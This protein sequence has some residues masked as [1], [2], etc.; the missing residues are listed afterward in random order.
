MNYGE[1]TPKICNKEVQPTS[2]PEEAENMLKDEMLDKIVK[3]SLKDSQDIDKN[4]EKNTY[5]K[6]AYAIKDF[7]DIYADIKKRAAEKE[8]ELSLIKEK[9]IKAKEI[10]KKDPENTDLMIKVISLK[11]K[12]H[13]VESEISRILALADIFKA[14][15]EVYE[16]RMLR[17]FELDKDK[18]KKNYKYYPD[19]MPKIVGK[20]W[21]MRYKIHGTNIGFKTEEVGRK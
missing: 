7:L 13:V 20:I 10:F 19:L 1:Q 11:C 21:K 4:N 14:D 16:G 18:N 9:I 15:S 2:A 12:Y 6:I 3:E 5:E 8:K 17:E